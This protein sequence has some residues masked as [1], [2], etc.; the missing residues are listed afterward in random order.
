MTIV[1]TILSVPILLRVGSHP[2]QL[3]FHAVQERMTA[4]NPP[5][6]GQ[7]VNTGE[8]S[9]IPST[10]RQVCDKFNIPVYKFAF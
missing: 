10:K 2:V 8:N 3:L 1:A 7:L 5:A 6:T 9:I 4:Q